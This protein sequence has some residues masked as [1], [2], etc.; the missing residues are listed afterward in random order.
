MG[1]TFRIDAAQQ[2][3]VIHGT[4]TLTLADFR[5]LAAGL[6][7]DPAFGPTMRQLVLLDI[8]RSTV[9]FNDWQVMQRQ[10]ASGPRGRRIAI[11]AKTDFAFGVA[12]Q[13]AQS[14]GHADQDISIFRE[15]A[16]AVTWLGISET[17]VIA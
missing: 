8:K 9:T 6:R 10:L 17:Q 1:F 2:L 14:Y 12:R 3:A 13:Y 11:V 15:R 4:E 16:E 5:E 7:A